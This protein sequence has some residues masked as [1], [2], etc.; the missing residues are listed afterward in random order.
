[1]NANFKG[2]LW[3]QGESNTKQASLYPALMQTMIEQWRGDFRNATLP[4]FLVELSNYPEPW[5]GV[6]F[7]LLRDAQAKIARTVPNVWMS[8]TID[9]PD[10]YDLH[11]RHKRQIGERLALLAREHTFGEHIVSSGPKFK[12]AAPDGSRMRVTFETFGSPLVAKDGKLSDFQLAGADGV[13]RNATARIDGDDSVIVESESV[14]QPK[15]VRY[16]FS[17]NPRASLFNRDGLPADAF[18]TDEAPVSPMLEVQPRLPTYR[19]VTETYNLTMEADGQLSSLLANGQQVFSTDA[20]GGFVPMSVWGQRRLFDCTIV[21]PDCVRFADGSASITYT[22]E[23]TKIRIDVQ[24]DGGKDALPVRFLLSSLVEAAGPLDPKQA[25]SFK[26]GS[27]VGLSI[28]GVDKCE[29]LFNIVYQ[30]TADVPAS[31]K[32]SFVID[33][34][35]EKK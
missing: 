5:E 28:A 19:V 15:F 18:R 1:V 20:Q 6:S 26:R 4:F 17:A 22:F 24:N 31:A 13:Y 7:A 21:G 23:P 29:K 12:S 11:P 33:I 2:V 10:G 9:T 25:M 35:V 14:S 30:L 34:R 27:D 3:Y 8:V 16:A 32:R